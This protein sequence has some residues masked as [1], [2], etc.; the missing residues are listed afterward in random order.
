MVIHCLLC[1]P[2]IEILKQLSFHPGNDELLHTV[3]ELCFR[4]FLAK[5]VPGHHSSLGTNA[6]SASIN[7]HQANLFADNQYVTDLYAEIIGCVA[8]HRFSLVRRRFVTEFNKLKLNI[9]SIP[10]S[11]SSSSSTSASATTGQSQT[12]VNATLSDSETGTNGHHH[13]P[14]HH[15][16]SSSQTSGSSQNLASISTT[17]TLTATISPTS[18]NIIKL[19]MGMKHFRIKM[20]PIE[21]FE[22]SFHFLNDCAQYFCEVKDKD[23]KHTLAGLFVEILVPITGQVKNEVNIPCLKLFVDILYTH[24]LEL[25][26]K[27]NSFV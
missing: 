6:A 26:A 15:S 2:L 4:R 17:N 27:V 20:V 23:I 5:E 24:A 25:S 10:T 18:A 12:S 1:I 9:S 13:H 21:D 19:L 7:A 22:A 11:T 16:S 14:H 8:Q 3:I